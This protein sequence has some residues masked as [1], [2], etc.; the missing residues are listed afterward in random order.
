MAASSAD[1]DACGL[2]EDERA[3]AYCEQILI[4]R[5]DAIGGPEF[6]PRLGRWD[7]HYFWYVAVSPRMPSDR[8]IQYPVVNDHVHIY[9]ELNCI[10]W[11]TDRVVCEEA[12]IEANRQDPTEPLFGIHAAI[13]QRTGNSEEYYAYTT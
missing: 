13:L 10:C 7:Q 1:S 12:C 2:S 9:T 11:S 8:E 5:N 4:Q 3:R 6:A